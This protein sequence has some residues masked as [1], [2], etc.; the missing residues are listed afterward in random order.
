MQSLI[1]GT[2]VAKHELTKIFTH[3]LIR[4]FVQCNESS[5]FMQIYIQSILELSMK[6]RWIRCKVKRNMVLF[7]FAHKNTFQNVHFGNYFK[8]YTGFFSPS[9]LFFAMKNVSAKKARHEILLN[10]KCLESK[11]FDEFF[12][13]LKNIIKNLR[14]KNWWI[15]KQCRNSMK[16]GLVRLNAEWMEWINTFHR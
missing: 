9:S 6:L 11:S 16:Y 1:T 8:L 14:T 4:H 13:S 15:R 3:F 2:F 10:E 7:C 5:N 12:K